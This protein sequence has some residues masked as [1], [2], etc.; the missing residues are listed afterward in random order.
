MSGPAPRGGDP[1]GAATGEADAFALGGVPRTML[2][3]LHCRASHARRGLLDDPE[4]IRIADALGPRLG[5]SFGWPDVAFAERARRFDAA[6]RAFLDAHPGATVVSLGEGLETQAHR[7]RGYGAW[8]T[9]DLPE[10]LAVRARFLPPDARHRHLPGS[11]TDLA[12]LDAL[13]AGPSF[14]VAQGLFM[15]LPRADVAAILRGWA[16]RARATGAT[17]ALMFDVVPPWVAALSR[18]RAPVSLGLRIPRM[19][20]GAGEAALRALVAGAVGGP[21]D[22]TVEATPLP[23]GPVPVAGRTH[24]ARVALGG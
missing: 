18:F 1:R 5:R 15:Y 2:W 21:H 19:P 9:V 3:T 8:W 12:W 22:L 10:A 13:G 16:T 6:L 11:A 7:V 14:V 23:S 20:W 17:A 4:A 24:L